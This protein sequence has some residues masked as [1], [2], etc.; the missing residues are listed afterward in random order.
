MCREGG[1][2]EDM[3]GSQIWGG[4]IFGRQ[5][6]GGPLS[7]AP[8]EG[9]HGPPPHTGNLLETAPQVQE[10]GFISSGWSWAGSHNKKARIRAL[11]ERETGEKEAGRTADGRVIGPRGQSLLK[12]K[13]QSPGVPGGGQSPQPGVGPGQGH[14]VH[15]RPARKC[16]DAQVY[17]SVT[18]RYRSYGELSVQWR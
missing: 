11:S 13:R 17:F 3:C 16:R 4:L 12:S 18:Q 1:P 5:K 8:R 7:P 15:G 10:Q 6:A 9:A 14:A 2:W